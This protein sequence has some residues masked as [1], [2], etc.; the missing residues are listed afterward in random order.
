[1]QNNR[2]IIKKITKESLGA[3]LGRNVF[4]ILAI[5]LTAF[6]LCTVFSVGMSYMES[7]KMQEIR[8]MG[9]TAH[10][11]V[12]NIGDEQIAM[13]ANLNYV[14][15]YGIG[16]TTGSIIT[17]EETYGMNLMPYWCDNQKW[18]N[19]VK[20]AY[21]DVVGK[22]PTAEDEIMMPRWVLDKLNITDP[23]IGMEITFP[24]STKSAGDVF[25][26][27]FRLSGWYTNYTYIRTGSI[28]VLYISEE[29]AINSGSTHEQDG[30]L[31][32]KFINENVNHH[33]LQLVNDLGIDIEDISVVPRFRMSDSDAM[34]LY[35]AIA[36]IIL[37]LMMTGYL[38]IYNVLQ[39][40]ISKDIRFYGLLKAVGMT[41]RQIS[42]TV[43]SQIIRLCL[44]G[45]PIGLLIALAFS[46]MI[47]PMF[48]T[49]FTM[50]SPETGIVISFNPL[51]YIG[52]VVFTV[53]TAIIG[54]VQP[55]KKAAR[56]SPI[57]AIRHTEVKTKNKV[58]NRSVYGNSIK[59]ALR[60]VFRVKKQAVVVFVS[61][62][63]GLTMVLI[64]TTLIDAMNIDNFVDS[65][66]DSDI[67]LTNEFAG[68]FG[69][70]FE[71]QMFTPDMLDK[72][73]A[74]QGL[75][76]MRTY[77]LE[78]GTLKYEYEKFGKLLEYNSELYEIEMPDEE[79]LNE[80][81]ISFFISL[82]KADIE[83][84]NKNADH[85][86]DAE[87]FERGEFVLIGTR[88]P[89]LLDTI[90]DID[91][92]FIPS[93]TELNI[94]LGGFVSAFYK[95]NFA[96]FA[97]NIYISSSLMESIFPDPTVYKVELDVE[98]KYQ[99]D[100]VDTIESITKNVLEITRV[101]RYETREDMKSAKMMMYIL[102]GGVSVILG[103]IGIFNFINLMFTQIFTRRHEITLL[104]SIGQTKKQT[105]KM[106][107]SEGMIYAVL[108]SALVCIFGN[109][110]TY[111]LFR[112]FQQQADYAVYK[113]P[114]I[115]LTVMVALVFIVCYIVPNIAYRS[116]SKMTI[117]ERLREAE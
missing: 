78:S 44:I 104:E 47:I 37:L 34:V 23:E 100:A 115:Q 27:T 89:E 30:S 12:N 102:G 63:L 11:A 21:V 96:G 29:F 95:T 105:L 101:S 52:A 84:L 67:T 110:I 6:M 81:F 2:N 15:F 25:T 57:E 75:T 112:M 98:E 33:A 10:A 77:Y 113:F 68:Y 41:P 43:Y 17:T 22:Y 7:Q 53:V 114:F 94:A 46:Y 76:A 60:N 50:G 36:I 107:I 28:D 13:L 9:T 51:I 3:N 117:V 4:L 93:E 49:G 61:L 24:I 42:D 90:A 64:V 99:K 54:V 82:N 91:I 32:I 65:Y 66:N 48:I 108:S 5:T 58:T 14:E 97:P 92:K 74:I 31:Q 20:P 86:L 79:E 40:S 109:A 39:I 88:K 69:D 85:P 1:M 35:A 19:L 87:A 83:Q 26:K 59:I 38:L 103:L 18:E 71:N 16:Y 106:L 116:I 56:I 72:F 111:G 70:T 8:M 62:F 73:N 80:F 55:A 45:V